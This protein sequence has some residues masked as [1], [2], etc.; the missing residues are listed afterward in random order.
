MDIEPGGGIYE[1]VSTFF[2]SGDAGGVVVRGRYMGTNYQDGAG[3]WY[4]PTQGRPTA[5]READEETGDL[6]WE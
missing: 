4:F 2:Y 6:S 1:G 3:P 5:H